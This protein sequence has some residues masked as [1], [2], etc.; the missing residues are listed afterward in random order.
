MKKICLFLLTVLL[1]L[2][3]FSC[4]E[5]T[6]LEPLIN[7]AP[8]EQV[9]PNRDLIVF[10]KYKNSVFHFK[11]TEYVFEITEIFLGESDTTEISVFSEKENLFSKDK[12]A[13]LLNKCEVE[14]KVDTEYFLV[15]DKETE[16]YSGDALVWSMHMYVE[17]M[18]LGSAKYDGVFLQL[19][20]LSNEATRDDLKRYLIDI[21]QDNNQNSIN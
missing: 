9:L 18:N 5:S 2:C 7:H 10:A 3:F 16:T 6:P 14:Y 15:L 12:M 19:T 13:K 11:Y 20:G 21:L 1:V 8:W 4:N 17:T